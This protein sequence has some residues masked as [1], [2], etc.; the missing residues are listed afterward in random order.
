MRTG[1]VPNIDEVNPSEAFSMITPPHG[2]T[3]EAYNGVFLDWEDVTGADKYYVR[4][5]GG[6]YFDSFVASESELYLSDLDPD[7]LYFTLIIPYNESSSCHVGISSAFRTG[8]E[9]TSTNEIGAIKSFNIYPN[10]VSTKQT[11]NLQLELES[12]L[13]LRLELLTWQGD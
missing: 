7:V 8:T 10:P 6:S 13:G 4:V 2:S 5:S 11:I 1:Y 9:S 12:L 3:T